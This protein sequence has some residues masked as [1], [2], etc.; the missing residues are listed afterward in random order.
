MEKKIYMIR[1]A[2]AAGQSEEAMLTEQGWAQAVLLRDFLNDVKID[3]IISSPFKRAL[4]TIEPYAAQFN[5]RVEVDQR[6]SERILSTADLPDWMEKLKAS[7]DDLDLA[8]EGG[9]S[10]RTAMNRA[11]AVIEDIVKSDAKTA[12]VVTHGNLLSLLLKY[13]NDEY[14]FYEWKKLSNPDVYLLCFMGNGVTIE[15]IWS[16]K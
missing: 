2:S 12:M 14:G 16:E 15:R 10:S 6:L 7:F 8:F 4:Q 1:H 3:R 5:M 13:Y 11:A 9:E